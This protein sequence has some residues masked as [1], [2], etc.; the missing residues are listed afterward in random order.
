M[1]SPRPRRRMTCG[2]K[3]LSATGL[4]AALA[5]T[6]GVPASFSAANAQTSPQVEG[7]NPAGAS[8]PASRLS[9]GLQKAEGTIAVYVQFKGKGAFEQTQSA[10]VL[11]RQEAPVNR[12]AQVQAIASQVQSQAQSV[13][14]AS[15]SKLMYTTHNA[16]RGAAIMGDA[17]QIRALANRPDVERISPI[18]AKERMNSGSEIDTKTLATWTRDHTGY[19]GKGVKIAIVDSGVDYTHADFGG[20]GTVDAYLKAKAMTELPTADSGLIDRTKFIGGVDLVG[21]DYNASDP[22]KS[23]PQPD[24]NP[25]DCRPDGFGSGGHGTHV[26]GTAAG[27]GV[28][29]SGTT[30]RGDYT[31]LTEDQLKGLSIGPG[32]APEAQL[33]AVRVFGCYGN[34]QMVMKAL[35]TVM[36]PNG[37][38]DFSDR[39]DIVN[40]SLGGE[41]APADDPESYMIDTMARQGVFTVAAAGNANN[42]N[43]VGDTYSDSGSPANAASALSVANAYGSTQPVDR[44]RITTGGGTSWLQ[45]DY[46]VNFNYSTA[47]AEQLR[48]EVVAAPERNRYACE[49]FTADE[50]KALKGKWVYI[51]WDKDDLSFPCGSKTRFDYVQAAGGL[52]VVMAGH[53]ERYTIGI[54]GNTTIPGIRLSASSS[55]DLE[56]ALAAGSVTVELSPDFK[57]SG[58]SGHSRAFDLNPSS[59]RGQHGSDGFIKPDLAAPGTEIVSAAVGTGSKGVSFTGT[60]MATPHVTGIAALVMQAHQDYNPQMLKAAL[61]NGASTS[62]KNEKGTAYAVDRVGTGMVNARAAVDA[63]VLA[64]DAKN[65]ERVSTAFGVLEYTPTSG[66]QTV[67]RDIVLDNTDSQ[68]H[69]YTLSYQASTNIPGV[70]YSFPEQVSVAAGER[71]NVTVTVRIDPSK[72][73]KTM[74]PAMSAD[75][76]AQDWT[77]GKTLAAGKRQYIASASGRLIFSENGREAIRQSIHVAPKPVSKMRVD[78]SRIDYKGI[79]DKE[80]TVTLRGTTLNQGG[81]RSLLGA[82]ELGAV[83]GRIPTGQLK[84]PSNQAVDLQYVGAAS[85]APALKAAGKNPNDGSLFF[86]IS[87]WGTWDSM[88]WGRQVQVQIDTTG[89][90]KADYTLE[91]TR[92]KGL[93]YPLVKVW[94]ISGKA[95]TVVARYPLNSAWGDTDT[96]TMDTN[97]MILGV[98]L[99]DLGLTAEKAQSIKY[100]VQTDTWYNEGNSYVDATDAITF[101]P[102]NPGVWFTGEESGVPGLFVDRDGG[103]LT[104]HRKNNN[105]ERQA[106][107][108]H[109]HNATGDLSGRKTANGVADGDRAQ[110]VDVPRTIHDARFTD[111]PADNQFYREITWIASH[112]ID[113]GYQDGT[114]RPLN[115]MDRATMA[116]YFYRMSGSPQFTAPSTPS[117]KDVPLNHPYYKEIEWMKAQGITTGWSDGTFRP[118]SSVN[119]DSMA[120]FFYR[121]AG[122]PAYEAPAQARFTDVSTDNL[123]YREISWL[124]SQGVT[125]GWPDG[126]FRP[127][128]PVHRDAMAAFVFRYSTSVLGYSADQ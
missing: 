55:K 124:A 75:Q 58:R 34:S 97:T 46:S 71:K 37:D 126:S 2:L 44:A 92:E 36:D 83:S 47:T 50:A 9:P 125:T 86:G 51:D 121:Y 45:G 22:A 20:P 119:R 54:G 17:A 59:A 87:T 81:Y 109:M 120:A 101:S 23:T 94:S 80:S 118:D 39:A 100:T 30:F 76:V 91:V 73:E 105:K 112:Q 90:S 103:Q 24:N 60:S 93:D 106:L 12:Q 28:T 78:A 57:A 33:L 11:A 49:A 123:F 29:E 64:Y 7:A 52:G 107:F 6:L 42:Y 68:A 15:G 3:A 25:L 113:R 114:F 84:L 67:Q 63:K 111:V 88:H 99:K 13:A 53:D 16:M 82:F 48:G 115:N 35:D 26:A 95:S 104:V 5:L 89:D 98:P 127:V 19:T 117:F 116:A 10:A 62:I 72:L 21:D 27:Y 122:S 66:I 85:D 32:T 40:L 108:L 65:P 4:S 110:V 70:E 56:K 1:T 31:K 77:T 43:G 61:M 74:D 14:A 8:N 128:E 102:F 41:F 18:I 38:G 79:A 96:N 69:T